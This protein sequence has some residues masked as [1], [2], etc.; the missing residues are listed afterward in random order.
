MASCTLYLLQCSK[1]ANRAV[2]LDVLFR[3]HGLG[4]GAGGRRVSGRPGLIGAGAD[5]GNFR[6]RLRLI[7]VEVVQQV[8]LVNLVVV[9]DLEARLFQ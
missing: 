6:L 5:R 9:I 2:E 4:G 3:L 1:D 7:V 8:A